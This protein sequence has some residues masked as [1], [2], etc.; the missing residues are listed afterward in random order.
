MPIM[1]PGW[2]TFGIASALG[3]MVAY[4]VSQQHV[5]RNKSA[6]TAYNQFFYAAAGLS[7][8]NACI[9]TTMGLL[10]H[11]AVLAEKQR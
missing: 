8:L 11:R 10:E 1:A 2:F 5:Y 6:A 7:L 3:P 9:I 4:S